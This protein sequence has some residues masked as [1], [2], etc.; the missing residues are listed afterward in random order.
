MFG[1]GWKNFRLHFTIYT[2]YLYV[3]REAWASRMGFK[4][5]WQSLKTKNCA[6]RNS[7]NLVFANASK[8]NN[9]PL[10]FPLVLSRFRGGGGSGPRLQRPRPGLAWGAGPGQRPQTTAGQA[11]GRGLLG[12]VG[13]FSV[14][15]FWQQRSV[16]AARMSSRE[17]LPR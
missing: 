7:T 17:R 16:L 13:S 4:L 8:E 10:F 11:V 6:K 12:E 1:V 9:L 15:C 5:L 3:K 14:F 2:P